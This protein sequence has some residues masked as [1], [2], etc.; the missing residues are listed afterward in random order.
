MEKENGY[1]QRCMDWKKI[2]LL[3]SKKI[4]LMITIILS[5]SVMAAVGYRVVHELT[6]G[7]QLYCVSSDYYITF[8]TKDH[9]EGVHHYNAY[10]WD[11]VLRDDPVVDVVLENL[12]EDYTKEEVKASITGEMLSDYR[13]LTVY[14][15]HADSQRSQAIADAYEIGLG[16]FANKL[17]LF[18]SIEMWSQ[19]DCIPVEEADLTPNAMVI[20]ALIGVVIA[21]L[22]FAFRYVLDDSIYIEKDF[23]ERF[24]IPFLGMMTRKGSDLCKQELKENLSYLLKEKQGYYLTFA[25]M[26]IQTETYTENE[27]Q[28]LLFTEIKELCA[29]VEENLSLRGSDLDKLRQSNGVILML[30][31]GSKNGSIVEKII[32]FLKKQE[33]P[34]VGVIVY[35]ADD[36]FVRKYYNK[37]Q[38]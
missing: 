10:T 23:A 20:G 9:P 14:S 29:G 34:L 18:E 37:K 35:N 32:E 36:A 30:P 13:I 2:W 16:L 3:Y 26:H 33:C 4:W 24:E 27:K 25:P 38:K 21:F 31:W 5:V 6:K 19:D 22:Y 17:D 15:T 28:Q 8:N 11:N 7:E 1:M 12:P